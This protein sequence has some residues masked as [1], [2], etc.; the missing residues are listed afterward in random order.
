MQD[1]LL[2]HFSEVM[3]PYNDEQLQRFIE[4][5]LGKAANFGLRSKQHTC[6]FLNLC[7]L[8]GWKFLEQKKNRWMLKKYLENPNI[9]DPGNRIGLLVDQCLWRLEVEEQNRRLRQE[10]YPEQDDSEPEQGEDDVS[11]PLLEKEDIQLEE[12]DG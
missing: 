6:Q 5:A 7:A 10:F 12:K 9:S 11:V 4:I 8:Y 1:H 3:A 2:S